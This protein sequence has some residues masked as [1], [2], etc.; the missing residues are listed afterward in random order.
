[1][2][3]RTDRIASLIRDTVGMLLLTKMSDPRIDPALT[4]ITRVE[5][6]ADSSPAAEEQE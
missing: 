1:M 6:P 5:V 2:S 3:R 4:S